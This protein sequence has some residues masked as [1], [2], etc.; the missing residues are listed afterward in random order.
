MTRAVHVS[1]VALVSLV[2]QVSNGDGNAALALFWSLVNLVKGRILGKLS[3]GQYF[4]NCSRQGRLAMVNV[5]NGTHI[6]MR[7]CSL[8]LLLSHV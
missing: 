6:H 7:L 8:K 5:S 4:R 3:G 1:I 2:L